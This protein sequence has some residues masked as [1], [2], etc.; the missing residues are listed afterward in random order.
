MLLSTNCKINDTIVLFDNVN[1]LL[2]NFDA[3][4]MVTLYQTKGALCGR[5]H[6]TDKL[7]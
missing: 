5:S 2:P 7:H 6:D 3:D 1:V 4:V